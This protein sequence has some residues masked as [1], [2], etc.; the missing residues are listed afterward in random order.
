MHNWGCVIMLFH[1]VGGY[2]IK[3][4]IVHNVEG[5]LYYKGKTI[6]MR[7]EMLYKVGTQSSFKTTNLIYTL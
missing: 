2:Y 7:G 3:G 4:K 1:I 5:S 6:H